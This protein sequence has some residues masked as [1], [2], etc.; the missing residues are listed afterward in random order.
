MNLTTKEIVA[1]WNN[2][3]KLGYSYSTEFIL[4]GTDYN[5]Y[6]DFR[7]C[8]KSDKPIFSRWS[9]RNDWR[10]HDPRSDENPYG[11]RRPDMCG[12][13]GTTYANCVSWWFSI[14]NDVVC[15]NV[16]VWDGDMLE[17]LPVDRRAE[18]VY[19]INDTDDHAKIVDVLRSLME[20]HI[21]EMAEG[22]QERYEEEQ[23]RLAV[24]RRYDNMIAVVT[25]PV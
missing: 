24:Q 3:N 4:C 1:L 14:V 16:T 21:W 6:S 15:L 25:A 7:R 11:S 9:G 12:D 20:K 19:V 5:K 23:R 10:N 13:D 8:L 22:E 18:W 17:G 2:T